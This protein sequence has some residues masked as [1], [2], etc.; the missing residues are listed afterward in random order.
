MQGEIWEPLSL[1]YILVS[2]STDRVWIAENGSVVLQPPDVFHFTVFAKRMW[3]ISDST[4]RYVQYAISQLRIVSSGL[5][6]FIYLDV[7]NF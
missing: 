6:L 2:V 4:S 1:I 7:G 3:R 5:H